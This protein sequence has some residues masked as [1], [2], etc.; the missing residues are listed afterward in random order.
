[1]SDAANGAREDEA[2][3]EDERGEGPSEPDPIPVLEAPVEVAEP[4]AEAAGGR[5]P[6]V[7]K[8][9]TIREFEDL[10]E[11]IERA[12]E[13]ARRIVEEAHEEAE[14]IRS[15]AAE[16]GRRE[17]REELVDLVADVRRR[18]R[19]IQEE[20]EQDMLDLAFRIARRLVGREIDREPEVVEEMIADSLEHV[21]G[22]RQVVV[23]VHPDDLPHLEE[24]REALSRQLDGAAIYFEGRA[25]LER[26][27]C[28]IETATERIDARLEMQLEQL[29]EA[30]EGERSSR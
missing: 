1:M 22:K 14:A 20:A 29:R 3:S 12:E 15:R 6:T 11:A 19:T 4:L 5:R 8:D 23:H 16:E 2:G 21:R 27:G 7:I 17:G 10:S 13:R 25:D 28:L 26:G 9:E 24:Q 30:I 18:Y